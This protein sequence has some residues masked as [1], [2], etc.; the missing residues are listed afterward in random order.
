MARLLRAGRPGG[1]EDGVSLLTALVI[2]LAVFSISGVWLGVATFEFNQSDRDRRREQARNAAEA[3]LNQAMSRLSVNRDYAGTA[4]VALPGGTGEYEVTVAAVAAG[5]S[6]IRRRIVATGYA[7]A[8]AAP[9][10]LAR[11]L[12]QEVG[13]IGGPTGGTFSFAMLS[14][15]VNGLRNNSVVNGDVFS[16]N[17]IEIGNNTYLTG[18][19]TTLGTF[20]AKNNATIG[21]DVHSA[22]DMELKNGVTVLGSAYSGGAMKL[23]E[24]RGN[25]QAAGAITGGTVG[26]SRSPFSPPD[27]I[28]FVP[29]PVPSFTW[30][31]AAYT[32]PGQEWAS[33]TL[34][35]LYWAANK[36]ALS[37]HHRV[38]CTVLCGTPLDLTGAFTMVGDTTVVSDTPI[39]FKNTT[40]PSAAGPVTLAVVSLATGPGAIE[41]RNNFSS[42]ANISLVLAA[43]NGEADFPNNVEFTG[44]VVAQTIEVGNNFTQSFRPIT[45]P[46]FSGGPDHFVIEARTFREVPVV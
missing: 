25:A 3:G 19:V 38:R 41:L 46:G 7:P 45:V 1:S 6:E 28:D 34:F 11:R 36:G 22:G 26:G 39:L 13:L 40:K 14:S 4:L 44:A 33:P 12:E 16:N 29:V 5:P 42:P 31:A 30:N 24:V 18:S 27:P 2:V 20:T 23:G 10:R 32:P 9:R 21:G 35:S 37:G 43:P 15:G 17:D 8:R